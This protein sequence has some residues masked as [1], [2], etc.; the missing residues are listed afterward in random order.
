VCAN[1]HN[2]IHISQSAP[3]PWIKFR[4]TAT[5][6]SGSRVEDL[7][8]DHVSCIIFLVGTKYKNPGHLSSFIPQ[9]AVFSPPCIYP[10]YPGHFSPPNFAIPRVS[11]GPSWWAP[12]ASR[13]GSCWVSSRRCVDPPLIPVENNGKRG[14][15]GHI[16]LMM[17]V[18]W[19]LCFM[20]FFKA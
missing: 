2:Q 10:I 20:L 5:T 13:S 3:T 12:A 7:P 14:I 4:P 1:R 8:E 6:F 18:C 15:L 16:C 19:L 11:L 9:N 17:C